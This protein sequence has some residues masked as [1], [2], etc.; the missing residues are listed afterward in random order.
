M[1]PNAA[2]VVTFA[3]TRALRA[4]QADPEDYVRSGDAEM[5]PDADAVRACGLA[6]LRALLNRGREAVAQELVQL[7]GRLQACHRAVNPIF[8]SRSFKQ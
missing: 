2:L 8:L 6:L 7:A 1:A 4:H 3:I 5:A